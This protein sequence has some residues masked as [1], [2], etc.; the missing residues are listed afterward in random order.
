MKK[1]LCPLPKGVV[2]DTRL[3]VKQLEEDLDQFVYLTS[4]DLREPLMGVAGFATLL[5]KRCGDNLDE[6]GQHFLEQIIDGSKRM[7]SKLDA[8]LAFSRAGKATMGPFPLG[9]AVEEA[10]RS[11]ALKFS[12]TGTVLHIEDG[13]PVVEG[14]R[15]LIAQVFQNLISNSIKYRS[16][17]EEP[18]I[19]ISSQEF[20]CDHYLVA[21]K[22]NGIG[23]DMC[24]KERIFGVFQRLYTVEEYPGTGIGL[25]IAKRVIERHGGEVWP[26]SQPNQGTVFYF[27]LPKSKGDHGSQNPSS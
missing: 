15:S 10:R 14:D 13:L 22:D 12:E 27:T 6:R 23:F 2:C 9:S 16:K 26:D 24:H 25:A 20:D 19:W 21:V 3:Q 4:H 11:L 5:Q 1:P 17:D 8:L 7:E 18:E